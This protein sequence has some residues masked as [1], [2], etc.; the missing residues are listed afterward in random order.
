MAGRLLERVTRLKDWYHCLAEERFSRFK[1][2]CVD[3]RDMRRE[4]ERRG[5]CSYT[6]VSIH[7]SDNDDHLTDSRI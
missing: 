3:D 6:F 7:E 5:T 2:R 1:G 4:D